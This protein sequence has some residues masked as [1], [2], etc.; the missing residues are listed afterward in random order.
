LAVGDHQSHNQ[1][2]EDER[3]A[4]ERD[5]ALR[6]DV[7]SPLVRLHVAMRLVEPAERP[8]SPSDGEY[9]PNTK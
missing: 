9:T 3:R 6:P 4:V 2:H 8:E 1:Q 5:R 7:P